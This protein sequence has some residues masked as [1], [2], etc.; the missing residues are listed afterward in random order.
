[1]TI[2]NPNVD[3]DGA[4]GTPKPQVSKPAIED[5]DTLSKLLDAKLKEQFGENIYQL[6]DYYNTR[7]LDAKSK[8]AFDKKHPELVVFR[9]AKNKYQDLINQQVASLASKMPEGKLPGLRV[10]QTETQA[11]LQEQILA[12]QRGVTSQQLWGEIQ[13][14]PQLAEMVKLYAQGQGDLSYTARQ[15]LEYIGGFYGLNTADEVL[16]VIMAGQ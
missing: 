16:Q 14:N 12:P 7:L 10:P 8:K 3:G 5:A 9:A 2:E 4:G 1:M 13:K 11:M 6:Y 15:R